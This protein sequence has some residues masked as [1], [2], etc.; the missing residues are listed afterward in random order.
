[1]LASNRPVAWLTPC[2]ERSRVANRLARWLGR[3]VSSAQFRL[4]FLGRREAE[5]ASERCLCATRY[6]R[7]SAN[8]PDWAKVWRASDH[9][10]GR[11]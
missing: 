2:R 4:A 1:M 10:F 5:M 11:H 9:L 7:R 3:G 6:G 8:A